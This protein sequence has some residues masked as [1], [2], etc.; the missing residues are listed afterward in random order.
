[1]GS[2]VGYIPAIVGGHQVELSATPDTHPLAPLLL[3]F[4]PFVAAEIVVSLRASWNCTSWNLG[5]S[6]AACQTRA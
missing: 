5:P 4:P 3:I 6:P 1:M 2:Q